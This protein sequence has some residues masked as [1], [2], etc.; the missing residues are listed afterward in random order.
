MPPGSLVEITVRTVGGRFLL[1]PSPTV[2]S[3]IL[4]V[5][6]RAQELFPVRIHALAVLSNH[7]QALVSAD[8]ARQLAGFMQHALTNIS[9]EVGKFHRWSGPLWSRR[10]RAIVAADEASVLDRLRYVLCQGLKEGLVARVAQWPGVQSVDALTKGKPLRGTWFDRTAEYRARRAGLEP[11][12]R[13]TERVCEARLSPIPSMSD[14][15]A[16]EYAAFIENLVRETEAKVAA[17]RAK[18]GR[19]VLGVAAILAQLPH[20]VPVNTEKSPAPAVHFKT[21]RAKRGFLNAYGAFV[22]AFREAA[23]ALRAGIHIPFPPFPEGAFPPASRFVS[24]AAS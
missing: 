23:A 22:A 11:N 2:N 8:D 10:Y 13:V 1:K 20:A 5:L 4:G 7:M 24:A 18:D 3:L 16:A 21:A 6:G 15:P 9:K 12:P 14:R 19:K 17:E